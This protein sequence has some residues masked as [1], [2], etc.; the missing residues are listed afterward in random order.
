MPLNWEEIGKPLD[1]H[2]KLQLEVGDSARVLFKDEGNEVAASAIKGAFARD[3][4]V[5]VLELVDKF[6]ELKKGDLV[7]FWM[8]KTSFATLQQIKKVRDRK[9]SLVNAIATI[10]RVSK[11]M[12]ET[13]YKI[14]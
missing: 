10:D 12:D 4:Y 11:K 1:R 9:G 7:E 3:S 8:S 6:K 13:N 2:P 5:F 14:Y